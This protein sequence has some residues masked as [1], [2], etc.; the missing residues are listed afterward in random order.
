MGIGKRMTL[1]Q[2]VLGKLDSNVQKD[3]TG[4]LSLHHTLKKLKM[5]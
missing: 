3:E 2:V 4:P 1:Q 5:D